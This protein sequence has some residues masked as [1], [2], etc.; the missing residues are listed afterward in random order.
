MYRIVLAIV[1]TITPAFSGELSQR[2]VRRS[3][4]WEPSDCD[5]PNEPNFYVS[6]VESFNQAVER[7][8]SYATDAETYVRCINSEASDDFRTLKGVFEDSVSNLISQSR[9]E[10]DSV[11]SRLE[12]QRP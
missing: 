9:N 3:T 7:Y 12:S 11:K 4:E 2:E 1:L 8:N 6:D 10:L 5:K